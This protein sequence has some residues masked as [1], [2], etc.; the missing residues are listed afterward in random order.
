[1]SYTTPQSRS[2]FRR[3]PQKSYNQSGRRPQ[4][5]R[6]GR[7]RGPTLDYRRFIK[8]ARPVA[9]VATYHTTNEF[10][11]FGFKP[12]LTANLVSR[13]YITPTPIQDQAIPHALLGKDVLGIANTGTGKT[14]AFLLPL[15]EHV[16]QN[17]K[18]GTVLI[19]APVRELAQQIEAE[20]SIFT[21][22]MRI[23]Y[24]SAI[25][26]TPIGPQLRKLQSAPH[27]IIG[28][29]G[30]ITD[31]ME[32]N[33][34]PLQY[35]SAIVL[36]EVDRML[37]MGF[38]DSVRNILSK[39]PETKQSLFFSATI[40]PEIST[41]IHSFMNDPVSV[42]VKSQETSDN[43]EQDV[44]RVGYGMQKIE[45][46][47]ELLL[48]PAMQKVLIFGETKHG[49][50][51]LAN[52]L[53]ERGFKAE[54]IHGN[55]SQGQRSRAITNFD[56]GSASIL[57]AT[58]VAARGLDIKKISHVI[59]YDLPQTY[60]DYTHRIGRTGRAGETGYALTFINQ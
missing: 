10:K 39:L 22:G 36:D 11:D 51:Q 5:Q 28:T 48:Q 23:G 40:S 32:R 25:G 60:D 54:T 47:H 31:L 49:V 7:R 53:N 44:V 34:L 46:L 45:V 2:S 41:L 26:G 19:I 6:G 38:I 21:R 59:N 33:V 4:Q 57:V 43:V 58:D 13:G 50:E 24:M 35:I 55:K 3:A 12:E 18:T 17:P 42:T 30:R 9:E 29:P 15:I 27:F 16:L 20:L 14:A 56:K 37:D 1:M 52:V 8:P